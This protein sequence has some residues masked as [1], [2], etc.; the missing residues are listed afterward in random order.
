MGMLSVG[1]IGAVLL[2]NIQDNKVEGDLLAKNQQIHQQVVGEEKNSIFG[3][4]RPILTDKVTQLSEDDQKIVTDVRAS[5]KQSALLT[6]AIFPFIMFICFL[7]L[8]FYFRSKGG[9]KPVEL[10][11]QNE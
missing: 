6:V 3:K 9:Y 10:G 4:Y 2:G 8:I 11:V 1:V 5:A 7:I